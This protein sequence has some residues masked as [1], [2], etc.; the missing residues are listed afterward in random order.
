MWPFFQTRRK[1]QEAQ[2]SQKPRRES[3]GNESKVGRRPMSMPQLIEQIGN[4][5]DLRNND[6]A[7]KFW[8]P[9]VAYR[10]VEDI[11]ELN[12]ETMSSMLRRFL[13]AHCYGLYP[14]YLI[15]QAHPGVFRKE[16][17]FDAWRDGG[18]YFCRQPIDDEGELRRPKPRHRV[19]TYWVPEL[20]KNIQ[21]IKLWIPARLKKDLGLLAEHV[22]LRTSE[23][24]REVMISRLLGY[25]TLPM[26]PE[27]F[28]VAATPESKIW[29]TQDDVE[30]L[31]RQRA[32][33]ED[34][35]LLH[36]GE[37]RSFEEDD[38]NI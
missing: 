14:F 12:D 35:F 6:A 27:A 9:E 24:V 21:P 33:M 26:R 34:N 13:L 10:A 8:L 28:K 38:E 11:S 30:Q 32:S 23:Y 18:V 2:A 36:G 1:Q 17:R 19:T 5:E 20:G 37:I 15:E 7:L 22:G 4:V 29:E 31:L 16:S 25:G 3:Q